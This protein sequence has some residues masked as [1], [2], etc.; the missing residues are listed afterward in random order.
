M[1]KLKCKV[2]MLPTEKATEI[3]KS[4][5]GNTLILLYN[6]TE[7][8]ANISRKFKGAKSQHLYFIS[9]REIKVGDYIINP[10]NEVKFVINSTNGLGYWWNENKETFVLIT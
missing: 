6:R 9:D 8:I 7:T 3:T 2:V 10:N 5:I 1:S 4:F